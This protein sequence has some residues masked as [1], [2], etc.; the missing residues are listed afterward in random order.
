MTISY[1][2]DVFTVAP[3]TAV[4]LGT[5]FNNDDFDAGGDYYGPMVV[6]GIP[7]T[8]NISLTPSTVGVQFKSIGNLTSPCE[9]DYSIQNNNSISVSFKVHFFYD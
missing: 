7:T 8:P 6:A 5:V 9:Y 4:A 1:G 2:Q 3:G